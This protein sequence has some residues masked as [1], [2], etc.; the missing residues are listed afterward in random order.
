[1]SVTRHPNSGSSPI[2]PD[3]LESLLK[4]LV[5]ADSTNPPG[6]EASTVAELAVHL[7]RHGLHVDFEYVLPGR[8]NLTCSLGDGRGPTL[9]LNAHTDTMP[10]GPG[11]SRPPFSAVVDGGVLYGR[12]ACDTKGGLAA[13]AEALVALFVSGAKLRGRV[14]LDAVIDEE[15]GARGTLATIAA[16]RTADWAIVA[17]PTDLVIARVGNGQMDAEI[18]VRGQAAHGSTPDEGRSAIADAAALVMEFEAAHERLRSIAHPL[19]GPASYS[20]G[21]IRGGVQASI[22]AAECRFELD[23]RILPGSSV[24]AATAEIDAVIAAVRAAR[25]GLDVSRVITLAIPPVE[26]SA[27]SPVCLALAA[28]LASVGAPATVGGL[29]ATSDAAWLAEAGIPTVV[30]GPGSLDHAH[31]PDE[32]VALADVELAAGALVATIVALVG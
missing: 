7:R 25:P 32:R 1:M 30:F 15:A 17:E 24:E 23:R 11:W 29:R 12:G 10:A 27:E 2:D 6:A 26:A 22:V 14:I 16:G 31:R 21:T 18:T 28:G 19:L 13:M 9:L 3:R 5:A 20:V 4:R 8:P